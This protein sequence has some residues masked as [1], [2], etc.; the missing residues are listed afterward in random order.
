MIPSYKHLSVN[1]VDGMKINKQ[2]FEQLDTYIKES[3]RDLAALQINSYNYGL[4][5]SSETGQSSLNLK[6]NIDPAK[7]IRVQLLSCRAITSGGC[8]IEFGNEHVIRKNEAEEKL[9]SEYFFEDTAE[10]NFYVL[11]TINHLARIPAGVLDSNE[12]P[13]RYPYIKPDYQLQILPE[14]QINSE[15]PPLNGMVIGKLRYESGRMKVVENYIPPCMMVR[16]NT[17]LTDVYFKLGNQLGETGKNVSTIVE[18]IHGKSQSISLVKNCFTLCNEV[19]SHIA[20][21]LSTY[22]WIKGDQPPVFMLDTFLKLAYRMF[23]CLDNMPVKDKEELVN[24][25]CEWIDET[26][27]SFTEK[28]NKLIRSEYKH[29]NI[30]ET[31]DIVIE[32]MD[33]CFTVFNKLSQLD[34]IGKKKGEGGFVME[35]K[36]EPEKPAPP[37]SN[38]GWWVPNP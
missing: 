32:F 19:A 25:I 16:S 8:R 4:C 14:S 17:S 27:A 37:K 29:T 13:P 7:I 22:R 21:E 1:W 23:I 10:K 20:N 38:T 34:F 26:P 15:E 35:K 31:L 6:I 12:N 24:Y 36:A 30:R 9:I 5:L 18:K 3:V 11:V 33:M 2:H 28:M